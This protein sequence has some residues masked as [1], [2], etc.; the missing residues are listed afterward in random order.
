MYIVFFC[1]CNVNHRGLK[2]VY[3]LDGQHDM[4]VALQHLHSAAVA[5]V[6]KAHAIGRHNLVPHIY[7]ILLGETTR[8][9]SETTRPE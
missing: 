3:H 7:S 1:S 6:L 5:D 4:R 8:I 9:Q 2:A